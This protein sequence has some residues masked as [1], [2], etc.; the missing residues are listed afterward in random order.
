MILLVG[1]DESLME[2]LTQ[3][4]AGS[5]HRVRLAQSIDEAEEIAAATPPLLMVLHRATVADDGGA[6]VAQIALAPGGAYVLYRTTSDEG[7]SLSL[8]RSI[9]RQTLADLSL[10]LER[11]RLLALAQY[12]SA[13]ARESGRAHFDTPPERRAN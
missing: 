2:G 5:G 9:A 13:R 8:A 11:H 10:P 1:R 4:L 12:V 3:L 6:R 7:D